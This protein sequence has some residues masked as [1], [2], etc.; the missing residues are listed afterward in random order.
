MTLSDERFMKYVQMHERAWGSDNYK[1]RPELDAI[2]KAPVV[3]MWYPVKRNR[4]DRWTITLHQNMGELNRHITA[5]VLHSSIVQPEKRLARIFVN[6]KRVVIK[7]VRVAYVG[8]N[9]PLS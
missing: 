6:Q 2:L 8:G 5:L 7:G 1:G 9:D 4:E 3:A